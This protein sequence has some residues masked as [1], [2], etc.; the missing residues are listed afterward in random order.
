MPT[1]TPNYCGQSVLTPEQA[2]ELLHR[3]GAQTHTE[4]VQMIA[5]AGH[6]AS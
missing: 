6:G 2:R 4:A 5:N 1:S 3:L